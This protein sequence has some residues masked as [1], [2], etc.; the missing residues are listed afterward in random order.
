MSE[1]NPQGAGARTAV[2][3]VAV[4]RAVVVAA[5]VV[6]AAVAAAAVAETAAGIAATIVGAMVA[7]L[8]EGELTSRGCRKSGFDSSRDVCQ[9]ST[10]C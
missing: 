6:R 4:A 2:V 1:R 10:Y 7:Q 8:S 3:T 9:S 5:V